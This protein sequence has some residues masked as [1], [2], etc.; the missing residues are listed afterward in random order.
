MG[1]SH[2]HQSCRLPPLPSTLP[3]LSRRRGPPSDR[4]ACLAT[5]WRLRS[6]AGG[7]A[8]LPAPRR[9]THGAPGRPLHRRRGCARAPRPADHRPLGHVGPR[10]LS[11][12]GPPL[13]GRSPLRQRPLSR[14]LD[15]DISFRDALG[16]HMRAARTRRRDFRGC[17]DVRGEAGPSRAPLAVAWACAWSARRGPGG[18]AQ[19]LRMA[20]GFR[21]SRRATR[22]ETAVPDQA[23]VASCRRPRPDLL[24]PDQ[25]SA[26]LPDAQ[27]LGPRGAL[28]PHTLSTRLGLLASPGLRVGE[29]RR[30]MIT[31]VWLDDEPP[32]LHIRDTTFHQS[33]LVPLPPSTAAHLRHEA[34]LRTALHDDGVSDV[35]VVSE[36][37]GQRCRSTLGRCFTARCGAVGLGPTAEGRRPRL[38]AWRHACAVQRLRRWDE[39]GVDRHAR[40]PHRAVSIGH[41]RPQA[42]SG[43]LSAT[44]ARLTAAAER[45][46]C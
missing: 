19:R 20:R 23:R 15:A 3:A 22:P 40:L 39:A 4:L 44:P 35:F 5:S 36:P 37:G 18:A 46:R 41:V 24:T 16:V 31:D 26:L 42:S 14:H 33:R 10:D 2:D 27:Q 8:G 38:R 6:T 21:T 12:R 29:A 9:L 13:D 1:T 43:Y 32:C 25:S 34:R 17:V 30:R 45:L 28:R 11:A 7:C